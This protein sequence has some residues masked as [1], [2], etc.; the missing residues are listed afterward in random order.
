MRPLD[1]GP[2]LI[3]P[4]RARWT[5]GCGVDTAQL[6]EGAARGGAAL[7]ILAT[8]GQM[9]GG[10]VLGSTLGTTNTTDGSLL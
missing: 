9:A 1:R 2:T 5:G 6:T 4:L 3:T 7:S 8:G 10:P